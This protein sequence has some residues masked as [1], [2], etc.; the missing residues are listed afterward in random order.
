MGMLND[1]TALVWGLGAFVRPR[2]SHTT[3]PNQLSQRIVFMPRTPAGVTV[4]PDEAMRVSAVWACLSVISK[5]IASSPWEVIEEDNNGNR[6]I[7]RDLRLSRM[8]NIRANPETSA[9]AFIEAA[10][11]QSLLWGNF[12]AEIERSTRGEP[13]ALWP[14]VPERAT[15]ERATDHPYGLFL[16]V[17]NA[18]SGQSELP[19]RDVFHIHGPSIDGIQ[20]MAPWAYA[21]RTIGH[22]AAIEIF[23]SAFFGNGLNASGFLTPEG[24]MTGEQLDTVVESLKQEHQ[25][26]SKAYKI[27]VL[28]GNLKWQQ[29]SIDPEKAQLV[30]AEYASIEKICRWFG[31]PPHKVAHLLRA[32]FSNI[33]E[34]SLE[35]VKDTITPWAERLRQEADA[36]LLPFGNRLL[37]TR[38]ELDWMREGKAE[39][40]AKADAQLV[41]NA[42]ATRDEVR[43]KRGLNK[44]SGE[45]ADVLT[46]QVQNVPL[47]SLNDRPA[48][49][50]PATFPLDDAGDDDGVGDDDQPLDL[51]GMLRAQKK[52]RAS[53]PIDSE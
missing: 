13:L 3:V 38:F 46:L 18:T 15:L 30:E 35:F 9:F 21:S 37:R 16:R 11:L 47:D 34:Q 44:Y 17:N 7:R 41:V 1:L 22:A 49:V 6:K 4:T 25:G 33:E 24:T 52:E 12:Y 2:A 39:D 23:G 31:V 43:A 50:A 40:T 27:G 48:P 42:I 32:T 26:P 20:G 51:T 53:A 28:R 8:L 36:K 19:Y 5:A 45:N 10:V 14:I 29:T